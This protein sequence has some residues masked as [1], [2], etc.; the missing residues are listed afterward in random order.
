MLEL[1]Q[2][3]IKKNLSGHIMHLFT[4]IFLGKTNVNF[5]SEGCRRD[6]VKIFVLFGNN[7]PALLS[8]ISR[9]F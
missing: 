6:R 2:R 1:I 5:R 8:S 9:L 7:I 4:L 3:K